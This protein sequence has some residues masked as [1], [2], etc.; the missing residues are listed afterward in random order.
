M[1]WA[2]GSVEADVAAIN[3]LRDRLV[4]MPYEVDKNGEA[5]ALDRPGIAL[6]FKQPTRGAGESAR[7]RGHTRQQ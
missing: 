4:E 3:H 6:Q 2:C 1:W 5:W 7:F